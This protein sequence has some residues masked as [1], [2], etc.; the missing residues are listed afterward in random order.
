MP[1]FGN[2]Y[3]EKREETPGEKEIRQGSL[4]LQLARLVGVKTPKPGDASA[5]ERT[6]QLFSRRFRELF[7][8]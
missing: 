6:G 1:E 3:R 7:K 5:I 2:P 4:L 8:R